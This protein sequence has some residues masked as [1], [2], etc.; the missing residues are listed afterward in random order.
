M[1][2]IVFGVETVRFDALSVVGQILRCRGASS[3][4]MNAHHSLCSWL[5]TLSLPIAAC[6]ATVPPSSTPS[7]VATPAASTGSPQVSVVTKTPLEGRLVSFVVGASPGSNT[8]RWGQRSFELRRDG[9]QT[10]L[11]LHDTIHFQG[12]GMTPEEMPP[13]THA[14]SEWRP[15]DEATASQVAPELASSED[16]ERSCDSRRATC[17]ALRGYLASVAPAP[18]RKEKDTG[19]T[20]WLQPSENEGTLGACN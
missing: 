9:A 1:E 15:L 6:G 18:A 20:P 3:G 10:M 13:T 8:H 14:C 2:P 12:V 4:A 11:R 5:L 19:T 16:A 7:P 17:D